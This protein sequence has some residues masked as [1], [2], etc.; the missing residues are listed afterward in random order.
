MADPLPP[1]DPA[2][3]P[4][5]DER[6]FWDQIFLDGLSWA[7]FYTL[8]PKDFADPSRPWNRKDG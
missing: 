6:A 4:Q 3:L 1:P 7:Q 8:S 5:A 2:R